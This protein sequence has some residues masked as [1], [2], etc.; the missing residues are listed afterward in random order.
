MLGHE[1]IAELGTREPEQ[2]FTIDRDIDATTVWE[3]KPRLLQH[4]AEKGPDL[5]ID[6]GRVSFIDSTGLGMLVGILREA[7]QR[8]GAVRLLNASREVRRILQ[9]TGLESLFKIGTTA[10]P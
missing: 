10:R 5:W 2:I 3:L 1:E 7:R 8:G 4:L 9:I 6:L